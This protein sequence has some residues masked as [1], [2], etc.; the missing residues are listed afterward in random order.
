M[1]TREKEACGVRIGKGLGKGKMR[2]FG[3]RRL[4]TEEEGK[5]SLEVASRWFTFKRTPDLFGC[6]LVPQVKS[7]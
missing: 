2:E 6:S 5:M 7:S 3:D 1:L 4:A